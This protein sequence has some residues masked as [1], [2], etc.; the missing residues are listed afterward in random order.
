MRQK[1]ART[2]ATSRWQRFK[3]LRKS[4]ADAWV[5]LDESNV[6][7]ELVC[8]S[9][10]IKI[11]GK[12]R[13]AW[14]PNRAVPL[15]TGARER[16]RARI[17][18]RVTL[19]AERLRWDITR[20]AHQVL[21]H[22]HHHLHHQRQWLLTISAPGRA[23]WGVAPVARACDPSR[24]LIYRTPGRIALKSPVTAHRRRTAE[25]ESGQPAPRDCWSDL[26]LLTCRLI[27]LEVS[28]AP[29]APSL[30][31]QMKWT[32]IWSCAWQNL[33][34]RTTRTSCRRTQEN[35]QYVWRIWSRETPSLACP[36]SAS[37]T[38]AVLMSG[39]K[40]TDRVLNILQIKSASLTF[41]QPPGREKRRVPLADSNVNSLPPHRHCDFGLFRPSRTAWSQNTP[42][43]S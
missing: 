34:W 3:S 42:L 28:S 8:L 15:P 26:Y 13:L 6:T 21:L 4:F 24:A 5:T 40:W 39:S 2:P 16:T 36:A 10:I 19:A 1:Q 38:K 41:A 12:C 17:S 31:L 30:S 7:G 11:G 22:H 37:I 32:F 33:E 20:T 14:A 18:R 27:S 9:L 25:R 29:S 43:F 35:V 23:P